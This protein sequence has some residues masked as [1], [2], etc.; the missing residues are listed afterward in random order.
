MET[1]R[2]DQTECPFIVKQGYLQAELGFN[3]N[4]ET[5]GS[6]YNLPSALWKYGISKRFELRYVSNLLLDE[7]LSFQHEA[8]GFKIQLFE[9]SK[10]LPRTSLIV[11]YNLRDD[12]RD[13]SDKNI[14]PHSLGQA[15]LTFQHGLYKELGMG[16]NFGSE[17][18]EDGHLE[19][20]YRVSPGINLTEKWYAYAEVF[21]RFPSTHVTDHWYDGGFAYYLSDH[22]KM[23]ISFGNSF[24]SA[25]DWYIALGFSFRVSLFNR[26]KRK[27]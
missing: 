20:I 17:V 1:D 19:G 3:K 10:Y 7:S 5:G 27:S 13:V 9:P 15:V 21:G 4:V 11:H 24:S 25:K 6:N 2:P 23:D 22:S 18:H 16:Y 14:V 12:K 8:I 26:T